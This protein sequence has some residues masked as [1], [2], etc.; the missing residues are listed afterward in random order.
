MIKIQAILFDLGGVLLHPGDENL[1]VGWEERLHLRP[2]ELSK[3]VFGNE[4]AGLASVGKMSAAD[5][6]AGISKQFDLDELDSL[7][8]AR[9]IW[10]NKWNEELFAFITSNRT[11]F[12]F[13]IISNNWCREFEFLEKELNY[14]ISSRLNSNYFDIII[15]SSEEGVKKPNPEIF[16]RALKRLGVSSDQA[17]FIDDKQWNVDGAKSVGI[18]GIL[19]V[20]TT[21][22]LREIRKLI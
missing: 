1:I 9:A 4:N 14:K 3:V 22:T 17:I 10:S 19:F 11:M 5:V 7:D 16:I 8:L 15:N 20:D 13:G 12:H 18:A 21:T 2:G 6:W